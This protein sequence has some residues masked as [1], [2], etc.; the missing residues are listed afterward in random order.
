MPARGRVANF[1][2]C[3]VL[4]AA[5]G[6]FLTVVD[7]HYAVH[8]WLAWRYLSVGALTLLWS[9]SCL[10]AGCFLLERLRIERRGDYD[11][12]VLAF[13]LGVLAFQLSIFLLGLV[14]WLGTAAF[15]GLPLGFLLAGGERFSAALYRTARS[16]HTALPR[17]PWEVALLL[18]GALGVGLLYFQILSPEPFSWDARWYHLPIAEQYALEG[19]VRPWPLGWWLAAYPH[20]ASLLYTWAFLLPMGQHFDRLELCAHLELAVFLGT[21]ASVPALV[22]TLVPGLRARWAWVTV[23]L[24]PGI[25]LYDGNLHAGA[26]HVAALWCIPMVLA[27]VRT[28]Q[29]WQAREALLFGAF[30]AGAMLSKYSAWSMVVLPAVLFLWR[31]AWLGG[32]RCL[33][34]PA[35]R[36]PLWG[37][38]LACGGAVLV[39]TAPHWLKNWLWYGDPLY[40]LLHKLLRVQ[41]WSAD[42][43]FTLH[44]FQDLFFPPRPGWLGVWDALLATVTFS[45]VPNDWPVFHR[46]VPIFGSLFTLT[47]ATL[48]FIR[49]GARLW[50]AYLGVMVAIVAWYLTNHQDRYLQAWLPCMAACTAATLA[51][52][53]RRR[54]TGVRALLVLLVSVQVL[55]GGDVPFLPT[56]N[57]IHDS[58]FR[59]VSNFLASGFLRTRHRLRPYGAISE[60]GDHLPR[61]ATL[62]VHQED[63]SLGV[64][65]RTV[66][67][68]WQ[69]LL[70][71][72]T[73]E[74]PA[75]IHAALEDLGITHVLW[76][77]E[78][79]SGYASVASDLAFAAFA[80]NYVED[81]RRIGIF[82]VG[83]FPAEAPPAELNDRV[84]A[85]TCGLRGIY[86]VRDFLERERGQPW[87]APAE[88][89]SEL[90][91][92]LAKA[93]FV[94]VDPACAPVLPEEARAQFHPPVRRHRWQL[95]A[96]KAPP[97]P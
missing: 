24:F 18:F 59:L 43:S 77:T 11:E 42:A 57:Q 71:Y 94:V 31:A 50:L 32:A 29:T 52:L 54:H 3:L 44:A 34:R 66:P 1:L 87:P 23:F 16:R 38:V 21:L 61:S 4:L 68:H 89:V 81:Q 6:L 8:R 53:W 86:R 46:D 91:A 14:G 72:G 27:L 88:Q 19:A 7:E 41:P 80:R 47:L 5:V 55:W 45:F 40:P 30:V 74:S 12:L 22:R 17:S 48:P 13:P 93:G 28:W 10:A 83:R 62:L 69:A 73:L 96:R 49:A 36:R 60:V 35:G 63:R 92:D 76:Q 33:G 37:A 64:R 79:A 15:V 39:L 85:L 58:P 78:S 2:L 75:K 82:T 84:L 51:L 65:V 95:Y 70:C 56:H 26:D 90:S 67:D 9:A 97:A 20:S 25:F